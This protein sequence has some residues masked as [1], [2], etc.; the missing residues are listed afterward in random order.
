MVKLEQDQ[1]IARKYLTIY[2]HG[3]IFVDVV[4]ER[5]DPVKVVHARIIPWVNGVRLVA[6]LVNVDLFLMR[7]HPFAR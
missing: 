6:R 3:E 4:V 5:S 2:V 1:F 7:L